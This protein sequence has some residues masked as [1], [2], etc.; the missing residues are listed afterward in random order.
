MGSKIIVKSSRFKYEIEN[1]KIIGSVIK[2]VE[3]GYCN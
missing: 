3:F 2:S 1:F